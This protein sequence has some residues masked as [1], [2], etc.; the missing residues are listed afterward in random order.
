MHGGHLDVKKKFV[1]IL[2]IDPRKSEMFGP[3]DKAASRRRCSNIGIGEIGIAFAHA[4]R[5]VA[6]RSRNGY[7]SL[8]RTARACVDTGTASRLF[9]HMNACLEQHLVNAAPLR[10]FP[11]AFGAGLDKGWDADFPAAKD[12]RVR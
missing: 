7:L 8:L 2:G 6:V 10:L 4:A 1:W 9:N 12:F 3:A 5:H 11:H